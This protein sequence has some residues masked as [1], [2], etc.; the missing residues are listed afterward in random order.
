[1]RSNE[2]LV[3]VRFRNE[4]TIAGTARIAFPRS[5]T[6]TTIVC[7]IYRAQS[8]QRYVHTLCRVWRC[9]RTQFISLWMRSKQKTRHWLTAKN[10]ERWKWR[11][12]QQL[13]ARARAPA[14]CAPLA[15][16]LLRS[17]EGI[18]AQDI[19]I[20]R[21]LV[22]NV[23]T[24][25]QC[26][27]ISLCVLWTAHAS[28]V[29]GAAQKKSLFLRSFFLCLNKWFSVSFTRERLTLNAN[30]LGRNGAIRRRNK[31]KKTSVQ[32]I[33]DHFGLIVSAKFY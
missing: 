23:L 17:F 30:C 1:M 31:Q 5:T 22:A 12:W 3:G 9:E 18:S 6:P 29:F 15:F 26:W 24:N 21:Q 20:N 2:F 25:Q 13:K 7:C 14:S 27:Y 19:R 10:E 8:M 16:V 28:S 32:I 33:S 4:T 11:E